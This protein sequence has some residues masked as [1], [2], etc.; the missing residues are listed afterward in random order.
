MFIF[1]MLLDL[2]SHYDKVLN[3]QFE[4]VKFT[5]FY[6]YWVYFL[7]Y[8]VGLLKVLG[9]NLSNFKLKAYQYYKFT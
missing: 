6:Q 5:L 1:T 8:K 3:I 7:V 9:I 4:E 2:T